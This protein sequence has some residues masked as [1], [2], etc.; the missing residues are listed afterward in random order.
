MKK[1]YTSRE[2]KRWNLKN[3]ISSFNRNNISKAKLLS[4]NQIDSASDEFFENKKKIKTRIKRKFHNDIK[5]PIIAPLD[6]RLI[7]NTEQCLSFIRDLRSDD[8]VSL[9]KNKKF[10]TVSIKDVEEI[11]HTTISILKAISVYLKGKKIFLNGD[12]P[13]KENC[14]SYFI[15]SGFLD[16]M[17][18]EKGHP[19][20]KTSKSDLIFFKKGQGRLSLEDNIMISKIII[21]AIN[22]LTGEEKH[23]LEIKSIIKEI[24]GNSIEWGGS[25]NQQWLLGVEYH[26]EKVLFTVTDVGKGII[27]TLSRKFYLQIRDLLKNKDYHEILYQAFQKQY[28]SASN[29]INRN[30]GLPLIKSKFDENIILNLIVITNNVILHFENETLS[31]TF[32]KGAPR[33]R[34]TFYQWEMTTNCLKNLNLV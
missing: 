26:D 19:Y 9:K 11:D 1:Y 24:C 31:K 12:F 18:D 30:H 25:N 13:I 21:K 20:Q 32:P 3:A 16:Q 10:I 27:E 23:C 29:E 4:K 15:D 5:P 6:L 8:Y 7:S 17:Y 14:R 22:H 34:G 33:F 28:H 2:Y